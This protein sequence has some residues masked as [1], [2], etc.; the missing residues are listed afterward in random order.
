MANEIEDPFTDIRTVPRHLQPLYNVWI[1]TSK[2]A[3]D[4]ALKGDKVR[5]S[6]A[7]TIAD[8]IEQVFLQMRAKKRKAPS[9]FSPKSS[10]SI[11]EKSV[12]NL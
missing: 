1:N 5:A 12:K 9:I 10:G 8:E 2:R 7:N 3:V 6:E 4:W 11:A